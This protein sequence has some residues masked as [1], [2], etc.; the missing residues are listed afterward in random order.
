MDQI[1]GKEFVGIIHAVSGNSS[2]D[3]EYDLSVHV[4]ELGD[5]LVNVKTRH[6]IPKNNWIKIN[7]TSQEN[8]IVI[9]ELV[10][11]INDRIDTIIEEKFNLNKNF[12]W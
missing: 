3:C 5:T 2:V 9:G 11:I 6:D 7:I 1:V 4:Y 8:N 12:Y 10:E